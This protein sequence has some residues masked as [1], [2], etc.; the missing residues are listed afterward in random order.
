MNNEQNDPMI[1][2]ECENITVQQEKQKDVHRH[3][4]WLMING[5]PAF[6]EAEM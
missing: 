5:N 1:K 4:K 2:E 3:N 6:M